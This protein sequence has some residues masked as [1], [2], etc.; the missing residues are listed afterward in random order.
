M[1]EY[2]W[3]HIKTNL[4]TKINVHVQHWFGELLGLK[5][6]LQNFEQWQQ[7]LW[8]TEAKNFQKTFLCQNSKTVKAII[9]L[10]VLKIRHFFLSRIFKVWPPC[11]QTLNWDDTIRIS[12]AVSADTNNK[13]RVQSILYS[14]L[15]SFNYCLYCTLQSTLNSLVITLSIFVVIVCMPGQPFFVEGD[16]HLWTAHICKTSRNEVSLVWVFPANKTLTK[17][18]RHSKHH[19]S[20]SYH[21]VVN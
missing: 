20:T 4:I 11:L 17:S 13:I 14:S 21:G 16:H 2:I 19:H 8:S 1:L 5:Y 10:Q 9:V 18:S 6:W 15:V 7:R 12:L 3:H